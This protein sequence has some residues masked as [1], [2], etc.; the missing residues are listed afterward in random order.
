MPIPVVSVDPG[1]DWA[2]EI[3]AS[4]LIVDAHNHTAGEGV[5]ITP[6]GMNI[7]SDLPF[8]D[9]NLTSARSV[10]FFPQIAPISNAADLGC[11]YESGVDLYYNDGAGNQIRITQSGS[12]AG[13]S[14]TITGLPSGTASASFAGSTFTFQSATN[15]PASMVFGPAKISRADTS[16]FGVT[17]TASSLQAANYPLVFPAALPIAQAVL[18]VTTGGNLNF[19]AL[20]TG[21]A[22]SDFAIAYAASTYTFNLPDAAGAARGVV[23][24][25]AQTFAG[26]K[27]FQGRIL[28]DYGTE[29]SAQYFNVQQFT[30]TASGSHSMTVTGGGWGLALCV[31][32]NDAT[33]ALIM[34]TSLSSIIVSQNGSSWGIGTGTHQFAYTNSTNIV[35]ITR[36]TTGSAT[37]AVTF[38][39]N[40]K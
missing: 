1:P 6:D 4:L 30:I 12:V 7:S 26:D 25:A 40:S 23:N 31:C 8:N 28:T 33:Q 15:T 34:F 10:R 5:A 35:T 18:G 20:A 17:L 16:G 29:T 27:T 32:D 36:N 14:G 9:N 24:T 38:I 22:G 11:L 19:N 2:T 13:S 37:Y 39:V 3:N 21:T